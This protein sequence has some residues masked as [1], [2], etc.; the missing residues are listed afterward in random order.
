[1]VRMVTNRIQFIFMFFIIGIIVSGCFS[2]QSTVQKSDYETD[3]SLSL[4]ELRCEYMI[5]PVGIDVIKPRLSWILRSEKRDQKQHAYQI[6][7]SCSEKK[8]GAGKGDM[9]DTGKVD[10]DQ[11]VH[12][13][14]SG[15]PLQSRQLLFWRVR[16]W[17]KDGNVSGWSETARW[18]MGLLQ[19]TDWQAKW[20]GAKQEKTKMN[21]DVPAPYFRKKIDIA[22]P[23]TSARVYI[24]GLG[25]YEFYV[26]GQKV[27]DHVLSPNQT[28]YDKRQK[29]IMPQALVANMSTRVLYE[30]FD[31]TDLLQKGENVAGVVLGNGWYLQSDRPEDTALWYNTPRLIAQIEVEFVDGSRKVICSDETWK[32]QVSP[33]LHNGLHT[34]EIYDARLEEKGWNKSG[35]DDSDWAFSNI[36][37]APEGKMVAQMSPPDRVVRTIRPASVTQPEEGVYRFDLGE[38]I[39][40]WARLNIQGPAGT[41]INL[42][43]IEEMGP[44][45]GQNDTY[46]LSGEGLEVWEPR[47]TWHA[48]RYV[49]VIGSPVQLTL[50][51][52]QGRVVNTD[53]PS[54]GTF[55]C[56]NTLFNRILENYQR[57]QLGN[58]HGGI[59]SDCPHRERRGYT[60]DGQI[61]AQVAIYNFDMS[62][63]YTKWLN[64]IKDAQ[65][66]ETGYVPNT[67][68]FQDGGGGTAWG[69]AYV[70]IPWYMYLYYGDEGILQTH[71]AGMKKWVEY[72]EN[73]ANEQGILEDQGLGDWI[74]PEKLELPPS[75]VNTCYY[76]YNAK[77]M[78]QVA[79]ILGKRNDSDY[80]NTLAER[81]K[82]DIHKVFF[83]K[84]KQNY[85]I[86]RQGANILP[87]GFDI[88]PDDV[89]RSVFEHLIE[90][91]ENK[92]RGHF[93]TGILATPLLLDVL[94]NNGRV[95]LAYTLL[96]QSDFPS[97]GFAIER[98][99]TTLWE[100][101]GDDQ[102]HSHPMFG[103]VCQWF[104]QALG[105]IK[106]DVNNP[107]FRN[108]IIKPYPVNGLKFTRASIRSMYGDISS[109]WE[110]KENQ[111]KLDVIVPVNSTATVYVVANSAE[112]V[113]ESGV[114][115]QKSPG[116]TFIGMEN[117]F[118]VYRVGSGDYSFISRD[119]EKLIPVPVI[120]T[121]VITPLDS[122]VLLPDSA[123]VRM[124]S[125]TEGTEI[126][127]TLDGQEPDE[128]SSL[129][130]KA[131]SVHKTT[132]IKAKAFKTG[133]K[134]SF[135]KTSVITFIDPKTNGL[136]YT[137]YEG[138]WDKLPDFDTLTPLNSGQ[139]YK[140]GLD[141]IVARE[142]CFGLVFRGTIDIKEAGDY[143]FFITSNDGSQLFIDD[144]LLIN[145]DG[146]HG[147]GEKS[148]DKRLSAGK[149]KIKVLYFQKGAGLY[150]Q[151]LYEG[152]GVKKQVIPAFVLY[153]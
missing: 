31:V 4:Q 106:A 109:R 146:L 88:V 7:V 137:Y 113:F 1:M 27:G 89:Y 84:T 44:S 66:S 111:F 126:R 60:G 133:R 5:D 11:S 38:M 42:R 120:A 114:V 116:V 90:N 95:D 85:S 118:A 32:T 37:T 17:D 93:D 124:S 59:P 119:I 10:S 136:N 144:T 132:V 112:R 141:E 47:F 75:L 98:G 149:H 67:V 142:D 71:Y 3:C 49:D 104:Y 87:L 19:A 20:I 121:P 143:R 145:N 39:S 14:Y 80:F 54:A 130:K 9:W 72:L 26:N 131:F 34:G 13:V 57:T 134:P 108:V 92:N 101:W 107:G 139:V 115:A 62:Q 74:A 29:E 24:S 127:Y 15:K 96:N 61:T 83:N 25:Y 28:N 140:I 68:P 35:Y 23:V 151:A 65:N 64:D 36:V 53:V 153:R 69:S 110:L 148:G 100:A 128:N 77:L 48:F 41:K 2:P 150:L 21:W 6:I 82:R 135:A 50:D 52:L 117:Q 152:P 12:I 91:V 97:F 16:V 105:G 125:E 99:A 43:F 33:I 76:S 79:E 18:E 129:Y 55:E 45:Y 103:S 30:T 22:K 147:P 94:T 58:M 46:I 102:S 138:D 86:G 8:S 63:F 51:N 122:L 73:Q 78:S 123:L 40:G 81:S 56:S 70:L